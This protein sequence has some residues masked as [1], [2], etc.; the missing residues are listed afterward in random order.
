[1]SAIVQTW[2]VPA[3]GA[4]SGLRRPSLQSGIYVVSVDDDWDSLQRDHDSP[5]TNDSRSSLVA[6]ASPIKSLVPGRKSPTRSDGGTQNRSSEPGPSIQ[7]AFIAEP[8]VKK[9][10]M[11]LKVLMAN[12]ISEVPYY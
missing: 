5:W 10:G 8:S 11:L 7:P 2:Y 9:A 12:L 1:V 6:M 4:S 3:N